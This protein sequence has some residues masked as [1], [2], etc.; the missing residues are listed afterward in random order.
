MCTD[1][2]AVVRAIEQLL[3]E[4]ILFAIMNLHS[5]LNPKNIPC[6]VVWIP[7][8]IEFKVNEVADCFAKS[9]LIIKCVSFIEFKPCLQ[10]MF[11]HLSVYFEILA[12]LM[13]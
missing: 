8:Y 13:G 4:G 5:L 3:Q 12:E 9:V 10:E 11:W 7:A 2:M 6:D 1:S